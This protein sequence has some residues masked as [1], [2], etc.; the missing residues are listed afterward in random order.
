MRKHCVA[1][2]FIMLVSAG[3][4]HAQKLGQA[5]LDSLLGELPKQKEDTNKVKLLDG[6]SGI[7]ANTDPDKGIKYAQDE[8][9][10]AETLGW[11]KG[12]GAGY[13]SLGNNYRNKSDFPKAVENYT[14]AQKL[15]E[16]I[17][18]KKG[19]ASATCCIGIVYNMQGRFPQAL[20]Y[21]FSS[22]KVQEEI[23]N[24][25]G[26]AAVSSD[27]GLVYKSQGNHAKALEY[28]FNA[29]KQ[30][31]ESGEKQGIAYTYGNIGNIY[32]ARKEDAKALEYDLK[33]LKL[34]EELGDKND[35]AANTGNI[36]NIYNSERNYTEAIRYFFEALK[37]N[38]ELGD[39]VGSAMNMGNIG[40]A[41]VNIVADPTGA[42]AVEN[43]AEVK[44]GHYM[45][46]SLIPHG[47]SALLRKA[48][49]YLQ[50][51]IAIDKEAGDLDN[52]QI[53][54]G[55][56]SGADSILGDYKGALANYKLHAMYI[57]SVYNDTRN[58]EIMRLGMVRK[59]D[60]DSLK[61]I[62]E[63]QVV[64]LKYRQQRNYT[65][66]GVAGMLLL[67]GFS[68]FIVRERGRSEA[69][70]K[71]SDDLLLN[72]LPGEV[73]DELKA[74]GFTEARHYQNVTVLFTDFVDFTIAGERMGPQALVDELHTCFRK[75]DEITTSH[76]VEK[77]KTI[78]DAY[79]A[80]SGLPA[81][82]PN[83]AECIVMA[84]I[85]IN[86]FMNDRLAKLGNSTFEMRVGIHSGSVVAGIVGVKKFAYDIWG[87]TVNTAARME[88]N[89]EAGR[90]NISQTTYELVK[91]KF[92][93][94]Y[95][96]EIEAKG[97]GMLKMYYVE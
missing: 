12:I 60:V 91:D 17:G 68:F 89:S 31:E 88:Q 33:A 75:F 6:L 32:H 96:G 19:I 63:R 56:L 20:D 77:I 74:N 64:E 84:A 80:V 35:I 5:R 34:D 92:S 49:E 78:G 87:D 37:M 50:K 18:Y 16:E 42:N 40:G 13:T 52:L 1:Y 3:T 41:Y 70:R 53:N 94:T 58:T 21:Y 2:L 48:V 93:C 43:G 59:M 30:Y 45:P 65:Y 82:N 47:R 15:Y 14:R 24:K 61:A 38:E 62:Q 28:E 55:M 27:I 69:E 73:A 57:D 44:H 71:K 81:A 23:G 4:L 36:G 79:L 54:Y 10:L 25:D 72:I 95:R 51:A 86:A 83:H 97:K 29:L 46:D 8:L 39:K 9:K 85:E 22:L 67:A 26:I 76:K 7:Y 90:I 11:K 66:L